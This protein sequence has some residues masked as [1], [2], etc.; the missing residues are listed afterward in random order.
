[1]TEPATLQ[2]VISA[3]IDTRLRN[4]HVAMPGKVTKYNADRDSVDVQPMIQRHVPS[5]DPE[6]VA[7]TLETLPVLRAVPLVRPRGAGFF[8]GIAMAACSPCLR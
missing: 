7:P 4:L 8:I 3:A 2:E 1:M 5:G 6:D